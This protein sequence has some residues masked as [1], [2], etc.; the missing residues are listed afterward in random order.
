MDV[1]V[2]VEVLEALEDVPQHRGDSHLVQH[3]ALHNKQ[4]VKIT[5]IEFF[6]INSKTM[7]TYFHLKQ[8]K[9]RIRIRLAFY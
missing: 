7:N 3:T 9:E 8:L 6:L 4:D 1:S 5:L 2:V